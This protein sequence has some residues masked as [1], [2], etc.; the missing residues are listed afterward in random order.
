MQ[1]Q[2][3]INGLGFG[4]LLWLLFLLKKG[5]YIKIVFIVVTQDLK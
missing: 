5:F 1:M 4:E 3:Q 2:L